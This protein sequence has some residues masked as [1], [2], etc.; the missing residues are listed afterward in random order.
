VADQEPVTA[1]QVAR[2]LLR[3]AGRRPAVPPLAD[4][5]EAQRIADHLLERY[6][7][8]PRLLADLEREG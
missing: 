1:D 4:L 2:A 7:D 5:A 8:L 3:A 6:P